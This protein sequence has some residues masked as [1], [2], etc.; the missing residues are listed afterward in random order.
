MNLE[1]DPK[2]DYA[3]K[4][5]FGT[6]K[7]RD[8][9]ISLVNAVLVRSLGRP[10]VEVVILNPFSSK[11]ADDDKS[12]V[13]DIKAR[14]DAGRLFNV[15]MQ[16]LT[17]AEI[18]ERLLY[19]WAGVF[20]EQLNAGEPFKVLKPTIGICFLD[21]I[22]F[23]ETDQYHL[24]FEPIDQK[25]GIVFS[26]HLQLHTIELPKFALSI[27]QLHD[28]LDRWCFFLRHALELDPEH[29]PDALSVPPIVRAVEEL[30]MLSVTEEERERYKAR[31]RKLREEASNADAW[32]NEGRAEGRAEGLLIGR[33]LTLQEFLGRDE[34]T[35][36][37][38]E[39]KSEKELQA[40][41]D[42][43][44]DELAISR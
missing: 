29:L 17:P 12:F 23:K 20:V 9:L 33:I 42:R 16:V 1:V 28:P 13:L 10:I 11:D 19:Y 8:I 43:M 39:Q 34:L 25:T 41:A 38:L 18:R 30:S 4:R 27:D 31:V 6:E 14:D 15:E 40:L 3:F 26:K 32:R 7:N 2:I 37:Q 22:L 21:R 44:R 35:R 5:V 36:E 24:V